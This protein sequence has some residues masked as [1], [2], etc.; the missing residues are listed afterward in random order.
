MRTDEDTYQ[1]APYLK[2]ARSLPDYLAELAAE[3][4]ERPLTRAERRAIT[5]E[6][7]KC[8]R[9][10][11]RARNHW[12]RDKSLRGRKRLKAQIEA[13]KKHKGSAHDGKQS[14]RAGWD[15]PG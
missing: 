9:S 14:K 10:V 7:R 5:A 2:R 12:E 13:D 1:R 8:K 4:D 3:G 15:Q 11:R 6:L